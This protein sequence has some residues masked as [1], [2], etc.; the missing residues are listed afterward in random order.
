MPVYIFVLT[1]VYGV[2]CSTV[3]LRSRGGSLEPGKHRSLDAL[4]STRLHRLAPQNYPECF[5]QVS[6]LWLW[7]FSSVQMRSQK[8]CGVHCN[9]FCV[10]VAKGG[11]RLALAMDVWARGRNQKWFQTLCVRCRRRNREQNL[12]PNHTMWLCFHSEDQGLCLW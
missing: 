3:W 7:C 10:L 6:P 8:G 1:R 2:C 12:P 5:P 4:P 9:F 11:E